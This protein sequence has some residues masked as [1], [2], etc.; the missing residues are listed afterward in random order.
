MLGASVMGRG[1]TVS[2]AKWRGGGWSLGELRVGAWAGLQVGVGL[3]SK[4][5]GLYLA[6]TLLLIRTFL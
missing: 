3:N 5:E 1:S 4:G 6:E 2:G